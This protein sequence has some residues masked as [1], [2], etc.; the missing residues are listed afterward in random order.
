MK[1]IN[2]QLGYKITPLTVHQLLESKQL[3]FEFR[4]DKQLIDEIKALRG[5]KFD[6]DSKTWTAEDCPRNWINLNYL[7][8]KRLPWGNK[9][10]TPL[11]L[12]DGLNPNLMAHQREVV[13]EVLQR[14]TCI[15]GHEPGL[16]KTFSFL[17]IAQQ[18]GGYWWFTCPRIAKLAWNSEIA[19]RYPNPKFRYI[20]LT[21]SRLEYMVT[22]GKEHWPDHIAFDESHKFKNP[23]AKRSQAAF[24]IA[25]HVR[26]LGR[27][28]HSGGIIVPGTG[29][30]SPRDPS[31]WWMQTELCQPG[32]LR[33]GDNIKLR[34]RLGV[35]D[36]VDLGFRKVSQQ[37]GWKKNEIELLYKRLKGIVNIKFKKDCIDLPEI[38]YKEIQLPCSPQEIAAA[39]MLCAG[40][41]KQALQRLRQLS[42]GFQYQGGTDAN[43][44]DNDATIPTPK[45][46]ALLDIVGEL[47]RPRVVI[48]A[49][50][51]KSIDKIVKLM[52]D[53]GW[54]TIRNDGRG[55]LSEYGDKW[56]DEF[57]TLDSS[58]NV[59]NETP[60]A[61]IGH[62]ESGG[63]SLTLTAA[64]T[65]IFYSNDF[66]GDTR[67]QAEQRIHRIGMG[68]K[69]LVY[70]LLWL[71]SD[72]YVLSAL[73]ER[74]SL[75]RISMGDLVEIFNNTD[76]FRDTD[77][78][79]R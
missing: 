44:N 59:A 35:F 1:I 76:D 9:F 78:I 15:M 67:T 8:T 51:H 62:P 63:V 18:V 57:C 69:A 20:L 28:N 23:D 17:E 47:T 41:T 34:K 45:D 3:L 25:D 36:V 16:G 49:A 46:E 5:A 26:G 75:E 2:C 65:A 32:F 39:R 30:P 14:G 52:N 61:Y 60:M 31:D 37:Q 54:S 13:S 71:P 42:D 48:F 66:R 70:D 21:H 50:Y 64:D 74:R 58:G 6:Y 27:A 24:I 19:L 22:L 79:V 11:A 56:Y 68:D 4:F 43:G 53:A 73:K 10:D 7:E 40:D 12:K 38:T 29:T 77:T 33:E 55:T 72:R